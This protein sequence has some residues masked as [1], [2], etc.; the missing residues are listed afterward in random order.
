MNKINIKMLKLIAN[1][2]INFFEFFIINFP[3]IKFEN[4]NSNNNPIKL[5]FQY[6]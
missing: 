6:E 3:K 5:T 1:I 4:T 2:K